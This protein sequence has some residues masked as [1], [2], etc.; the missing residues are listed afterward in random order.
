L[1]ID[2]IIATLCLSSPA[3]R[4]ESFE[5]LARFGRLSPAVL[6]HRWRTVRA[7]M[8]LMTHVHAHMRF[9][10]H[11]HAC[12]HGHRARLPQHTEPHDSKGHPEP[13]NPDSLPATN[14]GEDIHDSVQYN[15]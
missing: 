9:R 11:G 15:L 13:R 1:I 14:G 2:R 5:V 4:V 6:M 3:I 12:I 8:L 7:D 10:I